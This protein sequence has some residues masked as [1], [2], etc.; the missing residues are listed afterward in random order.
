ML[1]SKDVAAT[2]AV[3]DIPRAKKFY[4]ETLGLAE[5]PSGEAEVLGFACGGSRLMVYRSEFAGTNRATA[6]TW[7]VGDDVDAI[8]RDL[9][10]RGVAFERYDLPHTTREGDVHVAGKTRVAWFKDP[11]GNILSVVNGTAREPQSR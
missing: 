9:K 11:D 6:A 10:S 2:I 5:V 3:R 1:G 4:G 7:L 8:V